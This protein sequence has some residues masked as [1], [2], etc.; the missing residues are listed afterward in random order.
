M[1]RQATSSGDALRSAGGTAVLVDKLTKSLR[2]ISWRQ[3]NRL[4]RGG[5]GSLLRILTNAGKKEDGWQEALGAHT[6]RVLVRGVSVGQSVVSG[7]TDEVRQARAKYA[8]D[9]GNATRSLAGA[10]G[11]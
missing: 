8:R 7:Q 9:A 10:L 11:L 3:E 1:S 5:P 4:G 2:G 6:V